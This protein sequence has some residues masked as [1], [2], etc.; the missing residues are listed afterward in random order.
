MLLVSNGSSSK[1]PA[2]WP[3]HDGWN[4]IFDKNHFLMVEI[5]Y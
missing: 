1:V 3:L 2:L 4:H 5:S